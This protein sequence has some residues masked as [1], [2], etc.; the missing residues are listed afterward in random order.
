MTR[1]RPCARILTALLA[2]A[3][4]AAAQTLPAS[5]PLP[6]VLGASPPPV[7]AGDPDRPPPYQAI[8]ER[9]AERLGTLTFLRDLCGDGDAA[10]WRSRMKALLE[11]EGATPARRDRLAGAFNRGFQGYGATYRSCT[12]SAKLAIARSLADAERLTHD[13]AV[14][15]GG[16]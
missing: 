6:P 15:Y 14:Q 9:L 5:P 1:G 2:G 7:P 16:T 13:V 3:F 4:G 11:A 10:A 8:L 12:P